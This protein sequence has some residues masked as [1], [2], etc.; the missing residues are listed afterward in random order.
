MIDNEDKRRDRRD[1]SII[2]FFFRVLEINLGT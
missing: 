1:Q 2:N